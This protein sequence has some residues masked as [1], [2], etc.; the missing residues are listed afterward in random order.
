MQQA[1][2]HSEESADFTKAYIQDSSPY[3]AY[4]KCLQ[5]HPQVTASSIA[6]FIEEIL[7]EDVKNRK[8]LDI[9]AGEGSIFEALLKNKK[10]N[11]VEADLLEPSDQLAEL[12]R[13]KVGTKGGIKIH[14]QRF[15]DWIANDPKEQYHIIISSNS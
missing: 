7:E 9:G 14:Q 6:E 5:Y 3:L 8:M 2:S 15:Q 10:L 13:K 12:I 11:I 4:L 1:K